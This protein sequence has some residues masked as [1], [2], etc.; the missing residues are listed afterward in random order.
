MSQYDDVH[1]FVDSSQKITSPEELY[2]LMQDVSREMGFDHFALIHHVDLPSARLDGPLVTREL[3]AL[4]DYPSAWVDQYL[5][6][7]MVRDDPVLL[8]SRQTIAGFAWDRIGEL[9][10]LT[11]AHRSLI[12]RTREAG[13]VDGFTVPAY[14]PGEP[15]GSCNFAVGPGREIPRQNLL[16]AQLVG[17]YA[18]AAARTLAQRINDVPVRRRVT[19]TPRLRDCIELAARGKSDWEIG[20]ILGL[21]AVTVTTYMQRARALYDVPTRMQVVLMALHDGE[22]AFNAIL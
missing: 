19:L 8:A 7:H 10:K 9:I 21:S 6:E 12:E 18:F 14:V 15:S 2:G 13:I 3:I 4:S 22:I 1:C 17:S 16:M 5:G 11:A 20:Q